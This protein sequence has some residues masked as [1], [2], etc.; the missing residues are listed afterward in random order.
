VEPPLD[1]RADLTTDFFEWT[2]LRE[3][4]SN[5]HIGVVNLLLDR[6]ADLKANA[7]GWTALSAAIS[8]GRKALVELLPDRGAVAIL[9]Y[10]RTDT[11][12]CGNIQRKQGNCGIVT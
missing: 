12:A 7:N 5:G 1:W 6:G 8:T 11:S 4:V 9:R 2:I 3:A 10:R